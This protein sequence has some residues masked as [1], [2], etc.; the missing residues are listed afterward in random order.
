[1]S[2]CVGRYMW[3]SFHGLS[4]IVKCF[5]AFHDV[6]EINQLACSPDIMPV[7]FFLFATVETALKEEDSG[8]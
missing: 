7:H 8:H 1:M 6:V 4:M 2:N 3:S 5:L